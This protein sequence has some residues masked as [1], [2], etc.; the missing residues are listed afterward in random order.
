MQA[1]LQDNPSRWIWVPWT[2][3]S[4]RNCRKEDSE[5]KL[6]VKRDWIL[7]LYTIAE[8]FYLSPWTAL[9]APPRSGSTLQIGPNVQTR[10]PWM[11]GPNAHS[12]WDITT[13][14]KEC[15]VEEVKFSPDLSEKWPLI[16]SGLIPPWWWTTAL[17]WSLML[18]EWMCTAFDQLQISRKDRWYRTSVLSSNTQN[19]QN[20]LQTLQLETEPI[21]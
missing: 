15:F 9:K 11:T 8:P 13:R 6:W 19:W 16:I 2:L 3:S 1:R 20:P 21:C 14:G 12:T 7:K 5:L 17:V 10:N 18:G 4:T